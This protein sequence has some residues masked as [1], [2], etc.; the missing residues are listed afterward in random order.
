[1]LTTL[2]SGRRV[3]DAQCGTRRCEGGP[4]AHNNDPIWSGYGY[5]NHRFIRWSRHRLRVATHPVR[6]VYA[7]ETQAFVRFAS[8]AWVRC[9]CANIT[10]VPSVRLAS[11]PGRGLPSMALLSY[12][13]GWGAA[14]GG[15]QGTCR[16][17]PSVCS[18]PDGCLRTPSIVPRMLV[19]APGFEPGSR[20]PK[21]PMIGQATLRARDLALTLPAFNL[22]VVR[23]ANT[24]GPRPVQTGD[25]PP[26]RGQ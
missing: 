16:L 20:R 21:R 14:V 13:A 4:C 1:M 15:L 25:R 7:E 8:L 6:P 23:Q 26:W 18:R 11:G 22:T 2:A 10:G 5:V 19:G 9:S 12:L 24:R 3:G 17:L